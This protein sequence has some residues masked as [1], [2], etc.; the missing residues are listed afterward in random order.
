MRT[1]PPGRPAKVGAAPLAPDVAS[2]ATAGRS[3]ASRRSRTDAPTTGVAPLVT[4]TTRSRGRTTRRAIDAV[5]ARPSLSVA[6]TARS[7]TVPLARVIP[8]SSSVR[9]PPAPVTATVRDAV[10]PRWR[11]VAPTSTM[12][13]PAPTAAADTSTSGTVSV[14]MS[15]LPMTRAPPADTR[16][17]GAPGCRTKVPSTVRT[18]PS[19]SA[20]ATRRS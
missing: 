1:G 7:W 19:A 9:C 4:T 17:S 3:A 12:E 13:T 11:I 10:A 8:P 14:V 15:R 20:T 18:L 16:T 5:V 6:V 2:R